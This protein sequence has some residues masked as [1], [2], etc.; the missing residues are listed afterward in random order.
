MPLVKSTLKSDIKAAL[1]EMFE[2][3]ENP[4]DAMDKYAD[5]LSTAIDKYIKTGTVNTTGSASAQS[6]TIS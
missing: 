2:Q 1:K 6:G 4:E 5:K 3:T